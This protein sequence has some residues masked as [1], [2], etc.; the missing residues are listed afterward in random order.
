MQESNCLF[1]YYFCNHYVVII[2]EDKKIKII[3]S[4]FTN[5]HYS[6]TKKVPEFLKVFKK[7]LNF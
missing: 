5:K 1:I 7:I 4:I 3:D 6:E 2:I